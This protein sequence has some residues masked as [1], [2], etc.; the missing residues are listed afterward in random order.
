MDFYERKENLILIQTDCNME[1]SKMKLDWNYKGGPLKF[2]LAFQNVYFDLENCTGNIVPNE[3]KI[4]AL[5]ASMDDY[6]FNSVCTTIETL[7]L[8]TKTS[9]NYA[10]YLQSLI[11]FAENLKPST[12]RTYES[13][14]L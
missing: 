6:C 4:G 13:N 1:L 5:N 9:I 7:A 10:S 8:Q 12:S 14:K 3:E 2:F 11:K